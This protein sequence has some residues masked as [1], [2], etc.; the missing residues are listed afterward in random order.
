VVLG[1]AGPAREPHGAEHR[2][3]RVAQLVH[4]LA[5]EQVLALVGGAQGAGA[6]FQHVDLRL[7]VGAVAQ[8]LA[9]ADDLLSFAQR[10]QHAGRPDARAVL[11]HQPAVVLALADRA[12]HFALVR[13]RAERQVLGREDALHGLADHLLGRI[14]EHA[15]GARQPVEDA[16]LGVEQ[17]QR[18]V[19]RLL[20]QALQKIL[21]RRLGATL[22]RG[23]ARVHRHSTPIPAAHSRAAQSCIR[24]GKIRPKDRIEMASLAMNTAF[25]R[26]VICLKGLR[27]VA[28]LPCAACFSLIGAPWF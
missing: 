13:R 21:G 15:L 19:A 27:A 3:E 1:P 4:Q 8:H 25:S 28:A 17:D 18:M 9:E 7:Q 14:A 26:P 2:A 12:G 11:A 20:H 6:V 24:F 22:L 10:G 5:Q 16:A 23:G